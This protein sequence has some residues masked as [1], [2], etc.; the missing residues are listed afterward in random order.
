[1]ST[2]LVVVLLFGWQPSAAK[3]A[4]GN[5][6][7]SQE[8]YSE[9][10]AAYDE[11]L[12]ADEENPA[13][14]YNRGNALYRTEQFPTALEAYTNAVEGAPSLGG[15]AHYNMGNSLYRMGRLQ[16]SIEAYKAGLRIAPDD[17]D[18]K[19]NLEFVTRQ[20]QA[21][22][23]QGRE[24]PQDQPED[25][26]QQDNQDDP[27]D[28]P[29]QQ[30]EEEENPEQEQE[31]QEGELNRQQAQRLLDALNRDEQDLQ[32]RLRRQEAT[33]INPEKDW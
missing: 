32:H 11:A 23:A 21:Q 18:M 17:L 31:I 29:E 22:Q 14:H 13:L 25:Q 20:L 27:E 15:S 3:N 33:Q 19:Y 8:K 26:N 4:R 2:I 5:E 16:E 12:A 9:A 10:L 28:D 24:D 30:P 7:Y 1:M 6:L